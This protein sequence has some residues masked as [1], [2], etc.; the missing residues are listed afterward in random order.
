[1]LV[2]VAQEISV[3]R[4]ATMAAKHEICVLQAFRPL[5][6]TVLTVHNSENFCGSL[7]SAIR[8]QNIRRAAVWAT[9]LFAF[10]LL[11]LS[12]LSY[13]WQNSFNLVKV[14]QPT[15]VLL[16]EIQITCIHLSMVWN[17][18][19][20]TETTDRLREVIEQRKKIR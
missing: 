4:R 20:I 11:F 7:D 16:C 9:L 10:L 13:C 5:L 18:R 8:R 3:Q 19:E 1:M 12:D 2:T 15:S 17:N 14:A 6:R